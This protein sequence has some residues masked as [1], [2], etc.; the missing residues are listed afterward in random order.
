VFQ[1]VVDALVKDAGGLMAKAWG[2]WQKVNPLVK[3][4]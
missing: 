3:E 4:G 1:K 2:W